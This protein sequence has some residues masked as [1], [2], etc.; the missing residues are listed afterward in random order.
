MKF[1]E[2]DEEFLR[3]MGDVKPLVNKIAERPRPTSI[4]TP[5]TEDQRST[6]PDQELRYLRPGIQASAL[7]NLRRGKHR[8]ER[9]LDL[10]GQTVEHSESRLRDFLHLAQAAGLT[11]V[12][13]IHGKGHGSPHSQPVLKPSVSEW[14]QKNHLVL[15]F[16]S[17]KREQGGGGAVDVLIRKR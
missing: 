8:I 3:A 6:N 10:H 16:C 17:A 14:L 4:V 12:R 1:E 5:P 13:I 9:T 7:Q 11:A 2:E 15:A